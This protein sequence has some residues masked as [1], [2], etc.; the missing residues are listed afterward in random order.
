M[1]DNISITNYKCFKSFT[2]E[3][4]AQFNLITGKNNTGKS[5]L[6]EA[7]FLV[8]GG[9]NAS[10]AL[11]ITGFRGLGG[12]RFE[13]GEREKIV[14]TFEE[15]FLLPMFHRLNRESII[16]LSSKSNFGTQKIEMF[17]R[18]SDSVSISFEPDDLVESVVLPL[19]YQYQPSRDMDSREYLL[20]W[21]AREQEITVEPPPKP[22]IF[23]GYFITQ[24]HYS[25]GGDD[26]VEFGNLITKGDIDKYDIVSSLRK[27]EPNLERITSIP[28]P[29]VA[30]IYCKIK[31]VEEMLPILY[32]GDG[33]RRMV[34]IFIRIINSA[35][36]V[37][38]IDEIE[39]GFHYSFYDDMWKAISNLANQTNTQIF[40]TTHSDD[41]LNAAYRALHDSEKESNFMVHR[42]TRRGD[43]VKAKSFGGESLAKAM[44]FDFELR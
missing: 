33:V 44:D 18:K 29:G 6:L 1:L 27:I 35:G 22:P 40:A 32:L 21:Q 26:A 13:R 4:T 2:L 10:N 17:L 34:G 7:M 43:E 11:K 23:P 30:M 16:S 8:V 39:S 28:K 15:M 20:K 38:F 31:G 42:L 41:C 36:G 3:N 12:L 14:Q 37:L 25:G 9:A 5:S 24:R 19:R